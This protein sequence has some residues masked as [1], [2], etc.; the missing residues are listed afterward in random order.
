MTSPQITLYRGLPG[1]GTYTWSP[2]VNKLEARMRLANVAYNATEGSVLQSPRGKIPYL[3]VED[4]GTSRMISDSTLIIQELVGDGLLPDLNAKLHPKD[5]TLDLALR[6]LLEDRYYFLQGHEKWVHNYYTVRDHLFASFSYPLRVIIGNM[7][8]RKQTQ[9]LYNQGTLRFSD[10]EIKV[11]KQEI[12]KDINDLLVS[13]RAKVDGDSPFWALGGEDPTEVDATLYGFIVGSRVCP[14]APESQS[15][16]N[17]FPVVVEYA[18][19]I[20]D[21][22]FPDYAWV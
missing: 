10:E 1:H 18:K 2:F 8:Y 3:T 7:V 13:S 20:H 21:R 9:M 15:I 19:R 14:A 5:K 4:K 6:A 11:F 22:F 17:G 12:W 16:I